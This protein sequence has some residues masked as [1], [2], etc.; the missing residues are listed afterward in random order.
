MSQHDVSAASAVVKL[1][2]WFLSLA[3]EEQS[4]V[5]PVIVE[6][7]LATMEHVD[8]EVSA[9]GQSSVGPP[10]L[11]A[12][13]VQRAPTITWMVGM[14]DWVAGAQPPNHLDPR[15]RR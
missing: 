7:I 11:Q 14:T 2:E 5:A 15:R 3:P 9:F 13:N 12:L 10:L 4:A 6:G 8:E 1:E